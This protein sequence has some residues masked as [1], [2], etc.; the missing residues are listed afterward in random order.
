MLISLVQGLAHNFRFVWDHIIIYRTMVYSSIDSMLN[1]YVN[2]NDGL[3][4]CPGRNCPTFVPIILEEVMK[5][6]Y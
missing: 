6:T 2:R 4:K 1:A 3:W 5:V